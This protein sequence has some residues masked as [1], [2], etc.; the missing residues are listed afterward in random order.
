MVFDFS[1][2]G[3]RLDALADYR[4]GTQRGRALEDLV[5]EIFESLRGVRVAERNLLSGFG[6]AEIDST[7]VNE[8]PEYGLIGFPRD[9]L[10]ECK[11]S[12]A[13]LNAA[14]VAYFATQ[15]ARRRVK[16]SLIVS[17][18]G[19]TGRPERSNAA[20]LEVR[21]AAEQGTWVM[22]LVAE[23]LRALRS[24]EHLEAVIGAK[25]G[26]Q[27]GRM[28][29]VTLT[30]EEIANLDPN[31]GK[32]TF[33]RG[34][35]AVE[36]AIREEEERVINEVLDAAVGLADLQ[37]DEAAVERAA[38]SLRALAAQYAEWQANQAEDPLMHTIRS[39]V[40]AVGSAFA[41]LLAENVS[42]DEMR[43]IVGFE[44]RSVAP[45]RLAAHLGGELWD[46][47]SSYYVRRIKAFTDHARRIAVIAI[48]ALVLEE[49]VAIDN[50]D[51]ADVFDDYDHYGGY[52]EQ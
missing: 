48:L 6:E 1:T 34:W 47:L 33:S 21:R 50:I 11:S 5:V 4:A 16:W 7:W 43:R 8:S 23:E 49:I 18:N 13:P 39:A 27:F 30:A 24:A 37:D 35:E 42:E 51:P 22:V 9:V 46:L 3:S 26:R 17:L 25:H 45:R 36:R 44:V 28:I 31:R 40:V 38:E 52:E 2:I 15:A 19:I 14:G 10:M 12:Q 41:V 20:Q 29:A 32:I